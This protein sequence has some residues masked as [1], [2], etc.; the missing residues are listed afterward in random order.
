MSDHARLSRARM[1]ALG[2]AS[3]LAGGMPAL[4]QTSVA[5]MV[6]RAA[7]SSN[8]EV[9]PFL[10]ALE[11][12]M[13]KRAGIDATIDR[14]PSGSAIVAGVVGGAFDIGKSSMPSLLAAHGKGI[15][16]T[17]LAPGGEYDA[18]HPSFGLVIKTD[19]TIQS[20]A[21]L[22]GKTAAVSAIDDLYTIAMKTWID[23][24]GGDSSTVKLVEVPIST[25]AET[26][27]T[28]R[29]AVGTLTQPFLKNGIDGGRVK[30]LGYSATAIAP[31][32]TMTAWFARDDFAKKNPTLAAAFVRVMHDAAIYSNAHHA[33]TLPM[34]AK[35]L[36]I[37]P[38]D[39]SSL[40]TRVTAGLT[41]TPQSMKPLLDAAARY[42]VVS[43]PVDP[44]ELISPVAFR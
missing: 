33:E 14:L 32:F 38:Q 17:L 7:S 19:S 9:T 23:A 21:D 16:L 1:L 24:H 31:H 37:Q 10:Y 22:N 36:S 5:P 25:V 40:G 11:S 6:L 13:F 39:I 26:L 3:F 29:V 43:S 18:D 2:G 15:P 28:G 8:D 27:A 4:A 34:L 12:G 20:G 44:R 42:K 41:L 30:L 35:F